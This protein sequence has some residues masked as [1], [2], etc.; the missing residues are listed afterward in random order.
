VPGGWFAPHYSAPNYELIAASHNAVPRS[1]ASARSAMGRQAFP[2]LLVS[3]PLR[4][5]SLPMKGYRLKASAVVMMS[6]D[7][8]T[9][10]LQ[11]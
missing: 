11:I 3:N 8:L 4:P 2:G 6:L 7:A 9:A 5:T 10:I 1:S